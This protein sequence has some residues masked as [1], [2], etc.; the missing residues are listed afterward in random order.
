M[1]DKSMS[2]RLPREESDVTVAAILPLYNG[3]LWVEAAVRSVLAQ[4]VP[5]DEFII[6]DDGSLDGGVE[7]VRRIAA[8]YPLIRIISQLNAGQSAARNFAISM[9]NSHYV[10]LIDQDDYWYPDHLEVLL[11]AAANHRGLPLGWV[12]SDLDYIDLEGRMVSRDFI[13]RTRTDNPK[14][15]LVK[16]LE[17]GF[18]IQP[19]ATLILRAAIQAVHGFDERLSGYEDDDVFLRIFLANYDSVFVPLS[20]SQWRIPA[21]SYALLRRVPE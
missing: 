18:V 7:L 5:P 21:S 9:C 10:A 20:T 19:S 12:Y 17:Q 3:E 16:V 1:P 8:E 2:S 11:A 15:E 6:V 4:T 14:R 13:E